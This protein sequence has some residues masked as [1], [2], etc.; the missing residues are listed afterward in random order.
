MGNENHV[1]QVKEKGWDFYNW[2]QHNYG[3]SFCEQLE[4]SVRFNDQRKFQDKI[5][6]EKGPFNAGPN[7]GRR[8]ELRHNIPRLAYPQSTDSNIQG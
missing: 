7:H 4:I 1:Q 6:M 8:A 2:S 3:K 5:R